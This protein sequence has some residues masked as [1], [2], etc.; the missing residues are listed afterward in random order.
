MDRDEVYDDAMQARRD[1][2]GDAYVDRALANVRPHTSEFQ[3][4]IV[5][6]GWSVWTRPGLDHDTRRILVLGTMVALG[7]WEEYEMHLAAALE[8]GVSLDVVKEILIQQAVYCG[9]PAAN[10]AFHR[11]NAVIDR[12]TAQGIA[13]VG[14]KV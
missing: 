6:Y 11:L 14:L 1:V 8:H 5:R 12:L 4:M 9:V 2:L 7:R 10:T 3:E 13:I